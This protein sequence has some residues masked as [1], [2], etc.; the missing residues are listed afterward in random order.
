[1]GGGG[2]V[3]WAN[4]T[5]FL[6]LPG[7]GAPSTTH[8]LS[9]SGI[10]YRF[11]VY[12]PGTDAFRGEIHSVYGS[13]KV[14]NVNLEENSDFQ[15][16]RILGV[17]L[18][19]NSGFTSSF[20]ADF[21]WGRFDLESLHQFELRWFTLTWA[22]GFRYS[23]LTQDVD[24]PER[25]RF[26]GRVFTH[27]DGRQRFDGLGVATSFGFHV[28]V[29]EKPYLFADLDGA[30]ISGYGHRTVSVARRTRGN[31]V[32][33][34]AGFDSGRDNMF[35]GGIFAGAGVQGKLELGLLAFA[36]DLC[37]KPSL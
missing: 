10:A 1:M 25:E 17:G 13:G 8:D 11:A 23:H 7:N 9:L 6:R 16:A 29:W 33:H 26:T 3:N 12:N 4:N 14:S 35:S 21:H 19:T 5:A 18:R 24:I 30:L 27:I 22:L 15:S 28:P 34:R 2:R 37:G 36:S 32:E 31:A 20:E